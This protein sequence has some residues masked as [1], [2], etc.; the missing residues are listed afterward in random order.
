MIIINLDHPGDLE[1]LNQMPPETNGVSITGS[2]DGSTVIELSSLSPTLEELILYNVRIQGPVIFH[3]GL[4]TIFLGHVD[5][6]FPKT[7]WIFPSTLENFAI[8]SS[9]GTLD[10]RSVTAPS[11]TVHGTAAADK[12]MYPEGLESLGI[13]EL[14]F[15][16]SQIPP[17]LRRLSLDSLEENTLE[18]AGV[19]ESV[20]SLLLW[21]S[22]FGRPVGEL[23]PNLESLYLSNVSLSFGVVSLPALRELTIAALYDEEKL[24]LD[25]PNLE[26]LEIED[27][28][29]LELPFFPRLSELMVDYP[30]RTN[31]YEVMNINEYKHAWGL[32]TKAKNPYQAFSH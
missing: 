21:D 14:V 12:I 32:R 1:R 28:E 26:T 13:D 6:A 25:T 22:T 2:S 11:I 7:R 24:V 10:L 23:F 4:K 31:G 29:G 30:V 19:Y 16:A 17:Y 8:R 3:E 27:C 20:T 9:A 18:G 5:S 15:P